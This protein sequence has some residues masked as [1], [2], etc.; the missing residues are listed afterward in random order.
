M[1]SGGEAGA[2]IQG[3]LKLLSE[4][5]LVLVKTTIDWSRS[6]NAFPTFFFCGIFDGFRLGS[7]L[8][9]R[10]LNGQ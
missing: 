5:L 7:D 3:L 8:S 1:V 4:V 6:D 9:A 2:N 10:A